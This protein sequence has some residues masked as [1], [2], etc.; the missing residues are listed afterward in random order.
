MRPFSLHNPLVYHRID[1]LDKI[2]NIDTLWNNINTIES[3]EQVLLRKSQPGP[4]FSSALCYEIITKTINSAIYTS[5]ALAIDAQ[6]TD[7]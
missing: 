5:D 1:N 7:T 2:G 4:H 6:Q 3:A